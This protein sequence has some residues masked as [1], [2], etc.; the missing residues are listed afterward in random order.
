[1]SSGDEISASAPTAPSAPVASLPVT[2]KDET[3]LATR[4]E[5]QAAPV[6]PSVYRLNPGDVE[7]LIKQGEQFMAVGDLATARVVLQR[8]AETGNAGAALATGAT[9]DPL[10]IK[11]IGAMGVTA[12]PDKARSWY[13]KAQELGS[14]EAPRRLENLANPCLTV[15]R[16]TH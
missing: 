16:I 13:E 15:C 12:D 5:A 2:S 1:V 6:R 3:M 14:P 7:L 10:V 11:E 9:Y 4:S 8:A